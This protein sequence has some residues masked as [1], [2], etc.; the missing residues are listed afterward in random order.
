[1]I[2]I[3]EKDLRRWKLAR[4]AD[5]QV[6]SAVFW[7]AAQQS[8]ANL[9]WV[10][11]MSLTSHACVQ[12]RKFTSVCRR[13][14]TRMHPSSLWKQA[15][16]VRP[17]TSKGRTN[18]A[19]CMRGGC[20]AVSNEQEFHIAAWVGHGVER[21]TKT[22]WDPEP[23][24]I[25][26]VVP[27]SVAKLTLPGF[28]VLHCLPEFAQTHIHCVDNTIQPSHPLLLPSPPALHL[29]HHRVF[30]Q[31]VN[32]YWVGQKIHCGLSVRCYRSEEAARKIGK[33]LKTRLWADGNRF[34]PW[35]SDNQGASESPWWLI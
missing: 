14:C 10:H 8:S 11:P 7:R 18:C 33:S 12:L 22:E 1:M 21:K 34:K 30:S 15:V 13:R 29:S 6:D 31:W 16:G 17:V 26:I 19:G 2:A 4:K 9:L 24:T 28:P 32:M 3:V 20:K 5:G 23:Q 25:C 35:F 27:C